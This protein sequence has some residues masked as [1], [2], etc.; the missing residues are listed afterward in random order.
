MVRGALAAISAVSLWPGFAAGDATA[1]GFAAYVVPELGISCVLPA[2]YGIDD[3]PVAGPAAVRSVIWME[4]PYAALRVVFYCRPGVCAPVLAAY[5][6]ARRLGGGDEPPKVWDV[7]AAREANCDGAAEASFE[8]DD[9]GLYRGKV[10]CAAGAGVWYEVRAIWPRTDTHC[11]AAVEK[12]IRSF[13]V[14]PTNG[15]APSTMIIKE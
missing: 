10:L 14:V 5:G 8:F 4:A 2:G 15:D 9:G 6:V 11:E 12:V 1:D 7:V 13:K 3:T